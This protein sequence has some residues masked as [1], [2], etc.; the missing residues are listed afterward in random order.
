MALNAILY[1]LTYSGQ[2]SLLR[3]FHS[4]QILFLLPQIPPGTFR[5]VLFQFCEMSYNTKTVY[6]L[7]MY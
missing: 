1:S 6:V 5:I 4:F 2:K 3:N 7:N